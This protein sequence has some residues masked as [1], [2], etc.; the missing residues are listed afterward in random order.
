M[1]VYLRWMATWAFLAVL[2]HCSK[3]SD[4]GAKLA[5]T[6]PAAPTYPLS[7]TGTGFSPHAGQT[8]YLAAYDRT[9]RTTVATTS[10]AIAADGTFSA[11]LPGALQAG[12]DY[13]LDT[14]VDMVGNKTCAAP[15]TDHSWRTKIDSVTGA[16]SRALTH[17][18]GLED[19]C[20][21]FAA[22]PAPVGPA[23]A[24]TVSGVLKL[25]AEVTGVDGVTAGQSL[26]GATVFIAGVPEQEART[27][28]SGAF[29]LKL[30][31]PAASSLGTDPL[32]GRR[33]VMWYTI[34]NDAGA[35]FKWAVSKARFGKAQDVALTAGGTSDLGAV[36]LTFTKAM[37]LPIVAKATGKAVS[38]CWLR[39]PQFGFQL[40]VVAQSDGSYLIDYL[41]AG[42]YD[43]NVTCTG[44]KAQ[45]VSRSVTKATAAG[46]QDTVDAVQ[47]EAN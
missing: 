44:F 33:L 26:S 46:Q 18:M 34:P 22:A 35:P 28:A 38:S 14:Y 5:E 15:P 6:A 20:A 27:D 39:L 36:P 8:M 42:T 2:V 23:V 30:S 7:A 17:H 13:Y 21:S 45:T 24:T 9:D 31:L 1:A 41:P 12:R 40:T 32:A 16:V 47:L 29:T 3:A 25:G 19:V 43:I 10:V 4:S 11:T 37:V